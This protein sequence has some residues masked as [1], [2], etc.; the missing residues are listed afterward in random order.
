M[1]NHRSS[2]RRQPRRQPFLFHAISV[3]SPYLECGGL[4]PPLLFRLLLSR[5]RRPPSALR[6]PAPPLAPRAVRQSLASR[7]PA[8]VSP[9]AAGNRRGPVRPPSDQT[10]EAS[11]RIDAPNVVGVPW[12]RP[13]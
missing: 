4:L 9:N 3:P 1:A 10:P 13:G 12:K 6:D 2:S 5:K 8:D 11:A 7:L